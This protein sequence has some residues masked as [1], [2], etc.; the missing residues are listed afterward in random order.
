MRTIPEK[1]VLLIECSKMLL[2]YGTVED[3]KCNLL[4]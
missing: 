1:N 3:R 4:S 2:R